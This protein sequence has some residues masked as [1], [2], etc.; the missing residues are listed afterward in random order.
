MAEAEVQ[1]AL[2]AVPDGPEAAEAWRLGAG[3]A[4]AR[5]R[6]ADAA[7][8]HRL[9]AVGVSPEARVQRQLEE[10]TGGPARAADAPGR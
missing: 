4:R 5:G 3:V 2:A 10:R 9:G 7:A 1:S 8:R 6:D